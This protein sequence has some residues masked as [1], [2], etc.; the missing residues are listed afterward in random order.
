MELDQVQA[1][2]AQ[3]LAAA[4]HPA[5]ERL[6][7]VVGRNL[8]HAPAHL[9][10]DHETLARAL[11]EEPADEALAPAVAV[12]VRRVDERDAGVGGGVE[13]PEADGVVHLAP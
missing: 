3:A 7:R 10:G 9:G 13:R 2:D 5:P 4:V 6:R 12:H 8:R 11:A 1:L